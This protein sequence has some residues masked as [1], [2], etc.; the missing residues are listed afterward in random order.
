MGTDVW[1]HIED[2][3]SSFL[4]QTWHAPTKLEGVMTYKTLIVTLYLRKSQVSQNYA[5]KNFRAS[6]SIEVVRSIDVSEEL[7]SPPS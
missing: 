2:G 5:V 6:H 7:L 3:R 4:Q 1:V